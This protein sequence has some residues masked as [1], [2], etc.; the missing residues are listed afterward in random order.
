MTDDVVSLRREEVVFPL[1]HWFEWFGGRKTPVC[2]SSSSYKASLQSVRKS[3]GLFGG[4]VTLI[5]C[6]F[7]ASVAACLCGEWI[8]LHKEKALLNQTMPEALKEP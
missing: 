2:F 3:S 8:N 5:A 6:S 4:F 7:K 1:L